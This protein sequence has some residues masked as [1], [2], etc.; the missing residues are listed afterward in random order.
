M[1]GIGMSIWVKTNYAG[2]GPAW[3]LA[4]GAWDDSGVWDDGA[5][6]ID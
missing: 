1:L 5:V 6:W 3:I 2:G 4:L